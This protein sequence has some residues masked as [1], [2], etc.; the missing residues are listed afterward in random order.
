MTTRAVVAYPTFSVDDR[1]W[2]EAIRARNDSA[3][4]RIGAHV[5]LVFPAAVA[6]APLVTHVRT[7]LRCCA[8]IPIVLLRADVSP[9]LTEGGYCVSLLAEE[10]RAELLALHD[11]L[12][13][14][15]RTLHR[16]RD[17]PFIPHVTVG[18]HR[19]M[20]ESARLADQLNRERR[21]VRARI[22]RID[23]VEVQAG[24]VRS[25]ADVRLLLRG[26]QPDP[27]AE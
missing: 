24:M 25:V 1:Q 2:I 22:D 4:L 18:R 5:T 21:V 20:V 23:V 17:V 6:Q 8:S 7:T 16:R 12:Y 9:D 26:H 10:G 19:R 27:P 13:E 11:R 15:M 14:G 3:A